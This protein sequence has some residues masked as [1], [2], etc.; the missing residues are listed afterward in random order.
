MFLYVYECALVE[1]WVYFL[2]Y[3]SCI[4]F[5]LPIRICI[6]KVFTDTI[7]TTYAALCSGE[8]VKYKYYRR[9]VTDVLVHSNLDSTAE[10]YT[11]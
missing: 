10:C 2:C 6:N 9:R 7:F 11:R 5:F 4:S 1:R 3:V 8:L